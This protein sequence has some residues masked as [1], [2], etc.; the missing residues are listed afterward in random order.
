MLQLQQLPSPDVSLVHPHPKA[1][2]GNDDQDFALHPLILDLCA[3]CRLQTCG[4]EAGVEHQLRLAF[5]F[6]FAFS[7]SGS[8]VF[9]MKET[10]PT[11]VIRFGQCPEL[12]QLESHRFAAFSG[13][14]VNNSATLPTHSKQRMDVLCVMH[15]SLMSV[16]RLSGVEGFCF[17]SDKYI[18]TY[19]FFL[20][21]L[22][23]E[24]IK[25]LEVYS[26]HMQI[27]N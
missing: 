24:G 1:D 10:S 12:G 11:C 16:F 21:L 9:L 2:G 18:Q 27:I 26:Q 22:G 14:T 20:L 23:S 19:T 6:F 3:I 4:A 15:H 13:P 8:T 7:T 25:V 17:L 5:F